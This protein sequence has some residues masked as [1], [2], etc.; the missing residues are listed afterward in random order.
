MKI[1]NKTLIFSL[2]IFIT[3]I[4]QI[5]NQEFINA[6]EGEIV[7]NGVITKII[8]N[9]KGELES[10]QI[11]DNK[12]NLIKLNVS[13]DETIT[14]YGLENITGE[15]WVSNQKESPEKAS[16]ILK[17]HQ[18]RLIP[19]TVT[20]S[21]NTALKIVEKE[22]RNLETNLTYIS[23]VFGVAWLSFFVY[24]Y[25]VDRRQKILESKIKNLNEK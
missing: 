15:R 13:S 5:T 18:E 6:D 11:V 23:V 17:D 10:F 20:A 24:I 1:F 9:N 3:L 16:D 22:K 8:N 12:G 14:E 2:F 25:I 19:I 21:G 7:I 4:Y